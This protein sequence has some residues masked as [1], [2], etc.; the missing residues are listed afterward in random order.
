[1][2][3]FEPSRIAGAAPAPKRPGAAA[4]GRLGFA[5]PH[6]RPVRQIP[7]RAGPRLHAARCAGRAADRAARPSRL[8]QWAR[9]ARA[10]TVTTIA[11]CSM[12]WRAF[13]G[14]CAAS[15]SP[16][17]GSNREY[18]AIGTSSACAACAFI[19]FRISSST[20]GVGFDVF[21]A[22]R[23]TMADLGWAMQIFC[24]HRMLAGAAS[25]LR[26]F[27]RHMPVIVDHLGMVPAPAEV[28][29]SNFQALL[30]L[31]G[32][33]H[34]HIKLSAVYRL[35]G[36]YPDYP[37]ARPLHD[38]LVRANPERLMWGTDWPIPHRR[39]GHARRRP[40]ARPVP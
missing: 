2:S 32:D 14:G 23:T 30:K 25:S 13:H 4:T 31:V 8:R 20:G 29:E 16:T 7:L 11:C 15:P 22:F 38:A 10:R 18:R 6:F 27:S 24:D 37:D 34:V 39:R 3:R 28:A 26:E 9:G 36:Q 19:C 33:G 21:E 1:M 17:R 40:F 5:L 35:S 12:P